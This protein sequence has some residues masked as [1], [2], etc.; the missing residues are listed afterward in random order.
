MATIVKTQILIVDDHAVVREGLCALLM[1]EEDMEV[2]GQAQDGREGVALALK[3]GPDVVV[4]DLSMPVLN[5]LEA[6]RRILKS[7]PETRVI[8]LSSYQDDETV[9]K[10]IKAGA[11]GYLTKQSAS[12]EL[13][14]AVREVRRG[15]TFFSPAIAQVLRQKER[16][17]RMP[18]GGLLTEREA[19]VLQ[20]I[21]EGFPNK[22]IAAELGISIKTVEKHRQAVMG[23]L[24]IHE[25]AGLTRYA[26]AKGVLKSSREKKMEG[27]TKENSGGLAAM[28]E[29]Q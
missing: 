6:T 1:A 22:A 5:G 4:M 14:Q 16:A 25:A 15:K 26:I 28:E 19:Q 21:A 27:E 24:N 9:E 2:V 23:K 20:L 3:S 13:C 11:A 7:L 17:S 12:H 18:R 29:Q 8:V 10:L